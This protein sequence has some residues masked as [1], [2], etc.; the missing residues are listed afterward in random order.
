MCYVIAAMTSHIP[1][2]VETI[3]EEWFGQ[4]GTA[5]EVA[6]DKR[7]RWYKKDPAFDA[8]LREQYQHDVRRAL[9]GD[10][11]S[12]SDTA[13]G[14]LSLVILLDQFTRNIFRGTPDMYCGDERAVE[15][16]ERVLQLE[17][18]KVLW[19]SERHFLYMPLMHAEN[20]NRQDRCVEVFAELAAETGVA[21]S[22]YA[23]QHRDIVARFGRFPHRNE[24]LGR[25][26][27][28]EELAFLKQ[29]GSSF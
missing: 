23:K 17:L 12:W 28:A 7:V 26:S 21:A 22:D 20:V 6:D 2:R 5:G 29:P 18:D 4:I 8:H 16:T 10:Y 13:R 25:T 1:T 3:H 14:T 9:A 11:D 27:T 24:L 15:L 19:P